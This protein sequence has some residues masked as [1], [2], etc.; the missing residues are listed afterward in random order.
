MLCYRF[1][2][3]DDTFGKDHRDTLA[4]YQKERDDGGMF[5]GY[6]VATE[7]ARMESQK[8]CKVQL[9]PTLIPPPSPHAC[10]PPPTAYPPPKRNLK[11]RSTHV[12]LYNS[13][14]TIHQTGAIG[15][16]QQRPRKLFRKWCLTCAELSLMKA[17]DNS[18]VMEVMIP[19]LRQWGH[20][21]KR[22]PLLVPL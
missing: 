2:K 19:R 1:F 21:L 5:R 17:N 7:V 11:D 3:D 15:C 10:S 12:P 14:C 18:D 6:L 4:W 13:R 16:V 20:Y 8:K 9:G 22:L